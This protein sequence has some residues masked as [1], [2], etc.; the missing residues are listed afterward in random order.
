MLPKVVPNSSLKNGP[1]MPGGKVCRISATFLRIWYHNSGIS[2]ECIESR[3]MK[4]TC[5]SPGRENETIFSY[6]PVSISF[7]SM[8]S[9][10]W[11]ETSSALAP[12]QMVR[13]TM[14]LKVKG[15]SSLCPSLV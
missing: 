7:F 9:V 2:A 3:A 1:W 15:G 14:A 6:S 12:G 4:V 5:D 11:R 10:T 8:R 13:I